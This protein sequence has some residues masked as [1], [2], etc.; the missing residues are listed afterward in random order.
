MFLKPQ[1]NSEFELEY[2]SFVPSE[3]EVRIVANRNTQCAY[4]YAGIEQC[5]RR[6]LKLAGD[7]GNV[8]HKFGFLPC[9]RLVDAHYRC[10]TDEKY[11]YTIEEAPEFAQENAQKFFNCAFNK[12]EPMITCRKFFDGVLRDIYRSSG[13]KLDDSY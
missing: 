11:G 2:K 1:E 13:N 4:Y 10:L 9:K 5:R 6:M 7:P 3:G 12:L 8:N